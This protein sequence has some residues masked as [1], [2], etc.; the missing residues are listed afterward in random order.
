M[1][2][3]PGFPDFVAEV[4]ELPLVIVDVRQP[5]TTSASMNPDGLPGTVAAC[6]RSYIRPEIN[7]TLSAFCTE[8]TGIKQTDVAS[9]PLLHQVV[10]DSD[11]WLRNTLARLGKSAP[12]SVRCAVDALGI[13]VPVEPQIDTAGSVTSCECA[14]GAGDPPALEGSGRYAATTAA[15]EAPNTPGTDDPSPETPRGADAALSMLGERDLPPF[16]FLTDGPWDIRQFL[17]PDCH[18]KGLLASHWPRDPPYLDSWVD[19][20]S[21]FAESLNAGKR[22]N[23]RSMLGKVG[24]RF[25]GCEHSGLHDSFNI[26]RIARSML[27]RGVRLTVN[28]GLTREATLRWLVHIA[29]GAVSPPKGQLSAAAEPFVPDEAMLAAT[30]ERAIAGLGLGMAV[31]G[32]PPGLDA[33]SFRASVAGGVV[34]EDDWADGEDWETG[35]RGSDAGGGMDRG[36]R[37]RRRRR[38]SRSTGGV[39][40]G[41]DA[42]SGAGRERTAT[43]GA[44]RAS[45][46][47][48]R[49]RQRRA[50]QQI[51]RITKQSHKKRLGPL[52]S[53]WATSTHPAVVSSDGR[54]RRRSRHMKPATMDGDA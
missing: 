5:L 54:S 15:V 26:A 41:S 17:Q 13:P 42:V 21:H 49:G 35:S 24:L 6:W 48:S 38:G 1:I 22:L 25:L 36:G 37:G 2:A 44:E 4:I 9:A 28:D 23:L 16:A 39:G 8:L 52:P 18:R 11:S 27:A 53:D 45:Q 10:H 19:L 33:A 50:Q 32:S 14:S 43:E 30:P 40:A 46:G 31:D 7:P 3:Q 47:A 34:E 51:S 12:H 20:R 29:R